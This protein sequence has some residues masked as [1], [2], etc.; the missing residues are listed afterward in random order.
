MVGASEAGDIKDTV[1]K[2]SHKNSYAFSIGGDD[3]AMGAINAFDQTFE[4]QA[5]QI[6][7]HLSR[8]VVIREKQEGGLG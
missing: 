3:V 5:A 1:V 4:P 7:G 8:R 6:I 2:F